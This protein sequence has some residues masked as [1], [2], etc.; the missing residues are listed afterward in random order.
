MKKITVCIRESRED[1]N[2]VFIPRGYDD[3]SSPTTE[4]I[5]D[6]AFISAHEEGKKCEII[7]TW[8]DSKK[9]A[10]SW[11]KF[12]HVL[13]GA[14]KTA[15]VNY[16]YKVRK[17]LEF[18]VAV[19]ANE[20]EMRISDKNSDA[21]VCG[22][23]R[24]SNEEYAISHNETGIL[25]YLSSVYNKK[26][27]EFKYN[28]RENSIKQLSEER[29]CNPLLKVSSPERLAQ[30]VENL[31]REVK[32]YTGGELTVLS[33]MDKL[34]FT[35]EEITALGYGNSTDIDSVIKKVK[36]YL[37]SVMPKKT[38]NSFFYTK[39]GWLTEFAEDLYKEISFVCRKNEDGTYNDCDIQAIA[40]CKLALVAAG[41]IAK[42]EE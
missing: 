15:P 22:I 31:V 6:A 10:Y 1:E 20:I 37:C 7:V 38:V 34:N 27:I 25:N 41:A 35:E 3:I 28:V 26:N 8:P 36:K 23:K 16:Y 39:E 4:C 13:I 14:T 9:D 21:L 2:R 5:M 30:L 11:D 29:N 40:F 32:T 18:V 19:G 42:Q 33:L 17:M 12:W 24:I